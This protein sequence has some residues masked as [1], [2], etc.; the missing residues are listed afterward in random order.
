MPVNLL[1]LS[2]IAQGAASPHAKD[3][4]AIFIALAWLVGGAVVLIVAGIALRKLLMGKSDND[5]TVPFSLADLRRMRDT[6][7]ISDEEF[8]RAKS[9]MIAANLI[10]M[11]RRSPNPKA[12]SASPAGPET[13]CAQG[14]EETDVND[15][16]DNQTA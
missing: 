8:E 15:A 9:A 10:S 6:G 13:D 1:S 12:D 2:L 14:M 4:A 7:Q 11:N 16:S 5:G 3:A